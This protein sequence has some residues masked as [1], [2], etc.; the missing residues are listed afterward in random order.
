MQKKLVGKIKIVKPG[1]KINVE[2]IE[3]EA[4]PSYNT[5]K[6]FHVKKEDG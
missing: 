3:I 1:D 2:G 5:N 6:Q 4:V